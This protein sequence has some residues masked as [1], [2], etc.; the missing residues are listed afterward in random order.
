MHISKK[1]Y[2]LKLF[3]ATPGAW[4][5]ERIKIDNIKLVD[6]SDAKSFLHLRVG[7]SFL[8][9]LVVNILH[10]VMI[11][12]YYRIMIKIVC[13]A[14]CNVLILRC[15]YSNFYLTYILWFVFYD[16]IAYITS[17]LCIYDYMCYAYITL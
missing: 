17:C 3:L 10:N 2:D 8:D 14:A 4:H 9:V 11:Y 13:I 7:K 16:L 12:L 5:Q 15:L 1:I 6:V